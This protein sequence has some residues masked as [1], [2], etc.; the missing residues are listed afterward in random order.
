M[1]YL[2]HNATTPIAPEV[3]EAMRP[4][5]E[6]QFG[7]PSS[8][9]ADG[10]TAAAAVE[11][12]RAEVAALLGGEP[13]G[14]VFTASGSEADNLAIKGIALARLGERDHTLA[15]LLGHAM[16]QGLAERGLTR[17]R[18]EVIWILHHQG[19]MT[20]RELG[21]VLDC[22][23]PNVTGLLD[24]LESAGFV[25]REAHP[26]D[27]RKTLVALTTSALAR[28]PRRAP[29]T[30]SS[31]LLCSPISPPPSSATSSPH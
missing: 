30:R 13:D 7:N 15:A 16:D 20:Q 29:S 27:R 2:D 21:D 24:A 25:A 8:A 1:I 23:A 14:V 12:A 17:A 6:R 3:L 9:H 19:A 5:L 31:R 11:R 22:S 4:Y 18:G 10:A 28:H 26:T